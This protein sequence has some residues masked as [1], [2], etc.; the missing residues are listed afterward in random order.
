M[1]ENEIRAIIINLL[2][3]FHHYSTVP[4]PSTF[5]ISNLLEKLKLGI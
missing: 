3:G 1:V 4:T 2:H 5:S